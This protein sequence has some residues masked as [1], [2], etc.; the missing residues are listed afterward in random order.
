MFVGLRRIEVGD[1]E[2][3]SERELVLIRREMVSGPNK[4]ESCLALAI[5]EF[6]FATFGKKLDR[7]GSLS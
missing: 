1:F 5:S 4:A 7:S 6:D 2:T 3:E